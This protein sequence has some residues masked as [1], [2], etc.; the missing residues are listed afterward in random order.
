MRGAVASRAAHFWVDRFSTP[1][2]NDGQVHHLL[3]VIACLSQI[4]PVIHATFSGA[5]M[6]Q[7]YAGLMGVTEEP[8]VTAG[9]P[10]V[11][12]H[13]AGGMDAVERWI[14]AQEG[15]KDW[16]RE[17]I[18]RMLRDLALQVAV[19]APSGG[20]GGGEEDEEKDESLHWT[21]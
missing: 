6:T 21:R 15:A 1:L 5:S 7:K 12:V 14:T 11:A 20:G 2:S 16:S 19:T 13:A 8:F 18:A 10:L 17:E 9:N 3:W 4:V